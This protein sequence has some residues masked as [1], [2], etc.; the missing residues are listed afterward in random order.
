VKPRTVTNELGTQSAIIQLK[1]NGGSPNAIYRLNVNPISTKRAG[2]IFTDPAWKDGRHFFTLQFQGGGV[3][4][5]AWCYTRAG[6]LGNGQYVEI[7]GN[8]YED[9]HTGITR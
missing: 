1:G 9:D 7:K 3:G 4:G 8:L 6:T 2:I 5:K